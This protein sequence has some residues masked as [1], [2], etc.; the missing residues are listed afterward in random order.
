MIVMKGDAGTHQ[1]ELSLAL[2]V[3]RSTGG[4]HVYPIL[5]LDTDCLRGISEVGKLTK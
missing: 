4:I 2:S 3:E 1:F 5:L